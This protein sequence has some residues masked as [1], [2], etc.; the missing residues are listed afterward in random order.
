MKVL[1]LSRVDLY[2]PR[3]GDTFQMEKT[4]ESIE[5][6]YPEI[7]IDIS[8]EI[9]PKNIAKYD[10]VHIF[11]LDWVCESYPQ[12][13][14]AKKHG[15][16]V[17]L[18]AIHHAESEVKLYEQ[19]ARY[20]IR[21]IYNVIFMSQPIRDM[22]KNLYR[23]VFFPT[24]LAPTLLQFKVGIRNEQKQLVTK[25]DLV[26]VQTEAE[27]DDIKK[28]F[29]VADFKY[30]KVINGV[31][32]GLFTA[33]TSHGFTQLIKSNFNIDITDKKIILNVGRIEP[34]KNQ[35]FLMSAFN[36]LKTEG[37]LDDSWYLIFI[38]D[39]TSKSLEYKFRFKQLLMNSANIIYLGKQPQKIVA[40]AM[41]H[42]GIYV[43]PSWFET[44]GLVCMEAIAGGMQVVAS[45]TRLYEYFGNEISY[46]LPD[47]IASLKDAIL[48]LKDDLGASD[49]LK[50]KVINDYSWDV[51]ARETVAVY[52]RLINNV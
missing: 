25:S 28:D 36:Q 22:W 4:K 33:S 27:A 21:R 31:D 46:C 34:R 16:K 51:A 44:T 50:N 11:N 45:G 43:H 47:Q 13:L 1:Y 12:M 15:K 35:L 52:N 29:N 23:S 7:K 49:S 48:A 9:K 19:K 5:K 41:T 32:A 26:L 24:K 6:L 10:L 8:T 14:Y 30:A 39:A 20:D 38:G 18:S 2:N 40:S 3:G 42:K 37:K 17:I